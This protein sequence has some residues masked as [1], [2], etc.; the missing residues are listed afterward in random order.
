MPNNEKFTEIFMETISFLGKFLKWSYQIGEEEWAEDG[1]KW[2][3]VVQISSPNIFS[4]LFWS[5][6]F[7]LKNIML[8]YSQQNYFFSLSHFLFDSLVFLFL[9][10]SFFVY[11]IFFLLFF[12]F[13]FFLVLVISSLFPCFYFSFLS[14]SHFYSFNADFFSK[15]INTNCGLKWANLVFEIKKCYTISD[16][17][18]WFK[19][20][21]AQIH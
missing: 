15:K 4:S 3:N 18:E 19:T 2:S 9:F 7:L 17:K 20:K 13:F 11:F 21:A 6:M 10:L 1:H 8:I 14:L 5:K 16:C 12:T